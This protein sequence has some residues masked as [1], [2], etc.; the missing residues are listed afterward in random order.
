MAKRGKKKAK[1]NTRIK[2]VKEEKKKCCGLWQKLGLGVFLFGIIILFVSN[3]LGNVTG[4]VIAQ[5][6]PDFAA[7]KF[8]LVGFILMIA[9]A[10]LT[11]VE[12]EV[13][14]SYQPHIDRLKSHLTTN[15]RD[16]AKTASQ[17]GYGT[18]YE[19]HSVILLRPGTNI[20]FATIPI[21]RAGQSIPHGVAKGIV[22]KMIEDLEERQRKQ[23]RR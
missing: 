12:R 5:G 3:P 17:M 16:L 1:N 15:Y 19:E 6:D 4:N 21:P 7:A 8:Y 11:Q 14:K 9:G 23:E 2:I 13:N 10:L 18:R 22:D 20:A